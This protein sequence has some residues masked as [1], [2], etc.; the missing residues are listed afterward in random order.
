MYI[1]LYVLQLQLQLYCVCVVLT[2]YK[3][4]CMPYLYYY[5]LST[6]VISKLTLDPLQKYFIL[7]IL[8]VPAMFTKHQQRNQIYISFQ[9]GRRRRG[10]GGI[11]PLPFTLAGPCP[12][13]Q[14][15]RSIK[16]QQCM[17]ERLDLP[18]QR[19]RRLGGSPPTPNFVPYLMV[20][21]MFCGLGYR[22]RKSA[23]KSPECI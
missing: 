9:R 21:S 22:A 17:P 6:S 11:S 13:A 7:Y 3:C 2:S 14:L 19:G 12:P 1:M 4:K 15:H 5:F 8:L 16:C 23:Q 20:D 18:F 10:R